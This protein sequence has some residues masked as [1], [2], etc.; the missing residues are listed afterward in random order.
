MTDTRF[1]PCADAR[2]AGARALQGRAR[3]AQIARENHHLIDA[4]V[5]D[6]TAPLGRMV[7]AAHLI[8]A[9]MIASLWI[10]AR[11][12]RESGRSDLQIMRE[13]TNLL[14]EFRQALP[15]TTEQEKQAA[16]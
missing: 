11:R 10:R 13:A 2:E 3:M 4:T 8:D 7:T 15:V 6:L 5:R 12:L 1:K 16:E 9:E 14:R